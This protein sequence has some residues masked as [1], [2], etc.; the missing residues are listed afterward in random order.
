MLQLEVVVA[1]CRSVLPYTGCGIKCRARM[2]DSSVSLD[3]FRCIFGDRLSDRGHVQKTED[4]EVVEEEGGGILLSPGRFWFRRGIAPSVSVCVCVRRR[5]SSGSC[6][7][8]LDY[9]PT[10]LLLHSR[11]LSRTRWAP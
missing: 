7:Y 10:A 8:G 3:P 5:G 6:R 1:L 11:S 2:H 9:S 4:R